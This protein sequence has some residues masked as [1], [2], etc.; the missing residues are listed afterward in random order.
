MWRVWQSHWGRHAGLAMRQMHVS[1]V[2]EMCWV[3]KPFGWI[4]WMFGVYDANLSIR[5]FCESCDKSVMGNQTDIV[6]HLI[7]VVEKL[8]NRYDD[9]EKIGIKEQCESSVYAGVGSWSARSPVYPLKLA[10]GIPRFFLSRRPSVCLS[11][12]IR[13]TNRRIRN[14]PYPVK[15]LNLSIKIASEG[16][17]L[18]KTAIVS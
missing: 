11:V 1:G 12:R 9:W 13:S 5:W 4:V 8:V 18:S 7:S 14:D 15:S 16:P 3:F 6:E 17:L 2:L 10:Y